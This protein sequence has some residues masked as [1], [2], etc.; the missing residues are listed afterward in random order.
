VEVLPLKELSN[1]NKQRKKKNQKE[2]IRKQW[3]PSRNT[4][5]AT[6]FIIIVSACIFILYYLCDLLN[7]YCC[8]NFIMFQCLN[9]TLKL[10]QSYIEDMK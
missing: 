7:D 3:W 1:K 10:Q 6:L 2:R 8:S 5:F 4:W 9:Y